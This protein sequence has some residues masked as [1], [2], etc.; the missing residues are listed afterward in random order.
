VYLVREYAR[1]YVFRFLVSLCVPNI[2]CFVLIID[3]VSVS[4]SVVHVCQLVVQSIL[5]RID[6]GRLHV[7]VVDNSL[8]KEISKNVEMRRLLVFV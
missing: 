7:S 6:V 2:L 3:L 8:G 1:G 4:F 5:E